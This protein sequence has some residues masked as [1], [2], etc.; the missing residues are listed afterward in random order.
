MH[1]ELRNVTGTAKG[2]CLDHVNLEIKEGYLTGLVGKNGAGKTTLFRYLMQPDLSYV[3]EIL[4]DGDAN[5][6]RQPQT[7]NYLGYVSEDVI[8]FMKK[9]VME[10]ASLYATLYEHFHMDVFKERI[11]QM[12]ISTYS[13]L[14]NLSR[15]EYLKFQLALAMAHETKLY[16]LDEVTA[17]MDPVFRKDYFHMLHE[18]LQQE[19]VA[20]L[21]STH[22]EEEIEQYMDYVAVMEQGKIIS[23]VAKA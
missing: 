21:M 14:E 22:I 5:T 7:R 6:I 2:F 19:D 23:Y 20:I 15:G 4:I 16:L 12:K 17:G 11:R 3:G 1:V 18:I 9:T 10:N 13:A 8:C